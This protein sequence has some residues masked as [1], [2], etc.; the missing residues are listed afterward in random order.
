MGAIIE[1]AIICELYYLDFGGGGG[2]TTRGIGA[3]LAGVGSPRSSASG[4]PLLDLGG[5][6]AI[7]TLLQGKKM[8]NMPVH[9]LQLG[10]ESTDS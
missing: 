4:F 7:I 5:T 9:P 6:A 3:T 1:K 10:Q 8:K 2:G